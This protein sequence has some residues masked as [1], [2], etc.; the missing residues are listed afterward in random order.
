MRFLHHPPNNV[1]QEK[2][3]SPW[4]EDDLREDHAPRQLVFGPTLPERRWLRLPY[5]EEW[6]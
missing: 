5:K 6:D 1:N 4:A 3:Q 2:P